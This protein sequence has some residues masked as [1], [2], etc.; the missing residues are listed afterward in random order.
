[1][2]KLKSDIEEGWK[3][4]EERR[5]RKEGSP[6][7]KRERSR[8]QQRGT[9]GAEKQHEGG[10]E[11]QVE[12]RGETELGGKENKKRRKGRRITVMGRKWNETKRR[13]R[14]EV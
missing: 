3:D 7:G 5:F 10:S 14:G 6:I 9:E 11:E 13:W 12:R 8:K 2:K 1:M 4:V